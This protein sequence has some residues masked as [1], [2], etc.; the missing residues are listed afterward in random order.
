METKLKYLHEIVSGKENTRDGS[1]CLEVSHQL[2]QYISWKIY[3]FRQDRDAFQISWAHKFV[4]TF[5]LFAPIRRV[6]QKVNQD[7]C[8]MLIITPTMARPTIV[9]RA[10]KMSVKSSVFLPALK[11]LLKD[12]AIHS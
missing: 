5:P 3:P 12:P 9:S 10:S 8:L 11:D 7:Q 4:Y 1:V 6:L 2:L